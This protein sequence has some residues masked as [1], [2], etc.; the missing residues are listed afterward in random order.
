[1]RC[2]VYSLCYF[3]T[4]RWWWTQSVTT[5]LPPLLSRFLL[6]AEVLLSVVKSLH[7]QG[8][9]QCVCVCVLWADLLKIRNHRACLHMHVALT[10]VGLFWENWSNILLPWEEGNNVPFLSQK[11]ATEPRVQ[12]VTAVSGS[13][14]HH[15]LVNFRLCLAQVELHETPR[16]KRTNCSSVPHKGI[17]SS[18]WK[19]SKYVC[20]QRLG[21]KHWW[22]SLLESGKCKL[23]YCEMYFGWLCV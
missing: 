20:S 19:H 9:C 13:A 18:T 14:A 16:P 10:A 6:L 4:V 17:D 1:M 12:E 2:V 5:P 22:Q 11:I 23:F 21:V 7:L 8:G 3:C 15:V